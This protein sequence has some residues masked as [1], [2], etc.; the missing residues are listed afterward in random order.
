MILEER[1]ENITAFLTATFES[2]VLHERQPSKIRI[3]V[4]SELKD[5]KGTLKLGAM[6]KAVEDQKTALHIESYSMAQTSLEQIFNFFAQQQE[7]ETG[8]TGN[9]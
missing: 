9:F 4:P 7:E 2:F 6:F 3:E 5:G 8:V 1:Y